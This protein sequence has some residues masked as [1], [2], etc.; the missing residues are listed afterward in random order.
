MGKLLILQTTTWV[1]C[2]QTVPDNQKHHQSTES[3]RIASSTSRRA[4]AAPRVPTAV[5][6]PRPLRSRPRPAASNL[7]RERMVLI[8]PCRHD[9][10]GWLLNKRPN[11]EPQ[12]CNSMVGFNTI[13]HMDTPSCEHNKFQIMKTEY[14][15]AGGREWVRIQTFKQ[16]SCQSRF[17]NW[18]ISDIMYFPSTI[19]G[20]I[21]T[22]KN[23]EFEFNL[24]MSLLTGHCKRGQKN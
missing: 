2:A 23:K 24:C 1:K 7:Q 15:H 12:Y 8:S 10:P 18:W 22:T 11:P 13:R 6:T 14:K 21:I 19:F 9:L 3:R 5:P 20:R 16:N 17:C 4:H